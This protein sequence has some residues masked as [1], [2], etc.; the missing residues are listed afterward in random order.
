M[1]P[2]RQF[3]VG[4]QQLIKEQIPLFTRRCHDIIIICLEH[5]FKFNFLLVEA[6]G[7]EPT[8]FLLSLIYSQLPS[9]LSTHFRL[10]PSAGLEPA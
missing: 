8:V 6:V 5:H 10:V 7:I 9:P 3:R 1:A 2:T 4:L